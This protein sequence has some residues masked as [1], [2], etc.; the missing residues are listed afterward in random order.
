MKSLVHSAFGALLLSAVAFHAGA[1]GTNKLC[2]GRS[3]DI[4]IAVIHE[5]ADDRR[6]RCELREARCRVKLQGWYT[7]KPAACMNVDL[8]TR[9]ESYLS[10]FI[11][12][13]ADGPYRAESFPVNDRFHKNSE[14]KNSGI[15]NVAVCMPVGAFKKELPGALAPL[16][17]P[18]AACEPGEAL[19]PVNYVMRAGPDTNVMVTVN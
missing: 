1:T 3:T 16:L 2:N 18:A 4:V 14:E 13:K 5:E 10:I 9:W 17:N 19:H 7:L 12:D 8:G 6:S 15:V 11:K